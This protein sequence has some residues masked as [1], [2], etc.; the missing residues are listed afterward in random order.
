MIL[1]GARYDYTIKGLVGRLRA[2]FGAGT[3]RPLPPLAWRGIPAHPIVE[4]NQ[5]EVLAGSEGVMQHEPEDAHALYLVGVAALQ[6]GDPAAAINLI[7]R[8]LAIDSSNADARMYLAEAQ[9][10]LGRYAEAESNLRLAI[11]SVPK[12]DR[13]HNSLGTL[14]AQQGR[15][16]EARV[17]FA[18]ALAIRP[19]NAE[20]LNNLANCSKDEGNVERA[21]EL[22]KRA[23]AIRPAFAE[24]SCN[25][26]GLEYYRGRLSEAESS[27]RRAIELKP[28]YAEALNGLGVVLMAMRRFSEAEESFWKALEYQADYFEA[29]SNLGD[30]LQLGDRFDEAEACC[31]RALSMRP[32]D[33][34]T[35]NNLA[36]LFKRVGKY[37]DAAK[38]LREALVHHP[39]HVRSHVNL[40]TLQNQSDPAAAEASLRTALA[41]EADSAP[42]RYNLSTI[43]LSR[44]EYREGFDLYESRFGSFTREYGESRG[45]FEELKEAAWWQGE[46]LSGKRLLVWAEQGFGDGIMAMR[47]LPLLKHLGAGT[48]VVACD[49]PLHPVMKAMPGVGD[50]VVSDARSLPQFDI[51]CP[52]MSLPRLFGTTHQSVPSAVPYLSVPKDLRAA[53]ASRLDTVTRKKT[54][55]LAWAGSKT[56]QEDI[57]RSIAFSELIPLLEIRDVQWICLQ[58]GDASGR[59]GDRSSVLVDWMG[60]CHDFMDTASLV[61]CLDLVISVDTAAVHLAGALGKPVWLLNRHRGDWRWG[62]TGQTSVWYPTLQQFRQGPDRSWGPV[63]QDVATRLKLL[64]G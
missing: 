2:V 7:D 29:L 18:D 37:D 3:R 48:V 60:E 24:A 40:S 10:K 61:D 47:Y 20:A 4:E 46:S 26:G 64:R 50:V 5:Q 42:A 53:W 30:V 23:I 14:L 41:L 12:H 9:R 17:H 54:V 59:V 33:P 21:I 31:M 62:D 57:Q 13:A 6:Q 27:Y 36:T 19:E 39:N 55:G 58:K 16:N 43:L 32:R 45:L 38:C 34:E 56:L 51:H 44:G 49:P 15:V 28:A 35:L 1:R 11:A 63:I 8:T 25:L 22:Y 52:I